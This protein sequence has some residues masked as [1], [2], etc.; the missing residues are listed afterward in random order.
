MTAD[1]T[2]PSALQENEPY[3]SYKKSLVGA[4]WEFWL[5]PNGLAWRVGRYSGETRYRDIT[6]VRLSYRPITMQTRRFVAEIRS[7]GGPRLLI[8]SSSWRSMVEQGSQ[9]EPYSAFVREL[10]ARIAKSAGAAKFRA[11]VPGLLYWPGLAAFLAISVAT[12][13][14][15]VR[16]LLA[17]E[18]AAAALIGAFFA[19]FVWQSGGFFD[20]NRPGAYRPDA[21]PEKL[22]PPK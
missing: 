14:L 6:S 21:L 8:S 9:L 20:R 10:H 16:A 22:V 3:Y 15:A 11:G 4:P 17:G 7:E 12:L 13:S 1:D 18:W 5:R 19:M 2:G